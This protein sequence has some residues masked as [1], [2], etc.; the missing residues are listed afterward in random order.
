[1]LRNQLIIACRASGWHEAYGSGPAESVKRQ[2]RRRAAAHV[3]LVYPFVAVSE[4]DE[5][6]T[7][8]LGELF[9]EQVPMP[10]EF[11]VGPAWRCQ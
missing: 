3:S 8:A 10:V 4:L 1:M 5:R 7:S 2:S 9:V 6:V 11:L